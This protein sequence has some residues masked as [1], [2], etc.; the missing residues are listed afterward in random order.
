MAGRLAPTPSGR[1]HLGNATAFT[2]AW[3]SARAAGVPLLLR[4]EDV[5]TTRARADVEADLRRD[6]AWLGLHWDRETTRQ[7]ERDY[8]PWAERLADHTYRCTCTRKQLKAAGGRCACRTASHDEGAL[9]LR[10]ASDDLVFVDRVWGE[11]HVDPAVFG[12]PVL[13]RKDGVWAYNL[14]VVADDIADGVTEVVRGADL[15]DFTAVQ[16]VLWRLL[17]GTPPTWLHSPMVVGVDGRKLSKS[18]A[19]T[20]LGALREA[21]W[22][23]RDVLRTVLP[24][25][26]LDDCDTLH[27]AV[28][29]FDPD[30]VPRTQIALTEDPPT[31]GRSR[32]PR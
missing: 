11:R 18:H 13:Q 25:L 19:S 16:L 21:G 9:R 26:G 1:L 14:A 28:A 6:L 15:L 7:S 30:T 10:L 23:P 27:D 24:W 20:E 17:G 31:S 4:V 8:T 5:D 2:A 3:L 12:D 29:R 32:R 22:T